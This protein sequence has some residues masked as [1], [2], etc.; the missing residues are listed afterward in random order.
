LTEQ[1]FLPAEMARRLGVSSK[2]LR[3]Y[4]QAGL[5][6]PVRT[7]AGW[8]AY[9]PAQIAR[10]HQVLA[11]KSLGLSLKQIKDL[12]AGR[13]ASLDAVLKVQ[14]QALEAKASET[15][16]ALALL[17]SARAKL[18][19]NGVLSPDDLTQLTRETA[20]NDRLK[21]NEDWKAALDPII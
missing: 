19:A 6:T 14:Q 8:R 1:W 13:L 7:Q 15:R 21:T 4:E 5:V 18:A 10:L 3:V 12:L 9:G 11:L 2:A 20:M 17:Q 16:R